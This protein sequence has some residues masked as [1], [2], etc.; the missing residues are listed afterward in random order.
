MG[1]NIVARGVGN[2]L[3]LVA[4]QI[5]WSEGFNSEK[6]VVLVM[7]GCPLCGTF[8]PHVAT[9]KVKFIEIQCFYSLLLYMFFTSTLYKC[10]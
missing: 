8:R 3:S 4:V 10:Y 5:T 1:R 6:T 9:H 7:F 2:E